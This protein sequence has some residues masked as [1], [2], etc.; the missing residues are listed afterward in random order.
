VDAKQLLSTLN[1]FYAL[2]LLQVD[3]YRAQANLVQD[4]YTARVLD[5]LATIEQGHVHNLAAEIQKLGEEPSRAAAGLA[6]LAGTVAG[7]ALPVAGLRTLL[8][9][10]IALEERAIKEYRQLIGELYHGGEEDHLKKVLWANVVDE[11]LHVAWFKQ[12]LASMTGNGQAN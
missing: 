8:K 6:P 2:E 9:A 5:R 7:T 11:D 1:R 4:S 10:N 12:E 3:S